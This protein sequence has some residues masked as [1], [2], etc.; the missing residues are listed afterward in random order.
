LVVNRLATFWRNLSPPTLFVASFA[1]LILIGT[2]GFLVLP[3]LHTGPRLSV[4]DALFTATSAVCVTG[5][6]V[7]DTS[8]HFTF[9]GQLWLLLLIQLGGLG[10]LTLTTLIIAVLGRRL[11]LRSEMIAVPSPTAARGD[12]LALTLATGRFMFGVEAVGAVLLWVQWIG[13]FGVGGA[14]WHAVFHSISAFCNAGFS[15]FSDSLIGFARRPFLLL[16]ISALVIIGGLGY[17]ACE[18]LLRW[19]HARVARIRGGRLSTHTFVAVVTSAILL[20]AGTVAFAVIEWNGVLAPMGFIDRVSNAW[21]LSMTPRTAGFNTVSYAR[22][23]NA[24]VLVT[25]FLMFVGGSPGSTAGGVKTTS[26]AIIFAL[27]RSRMAG[28]RYVELHGRTVPDGTIQR[29]VS[30]VLIGSALVLVGLFALTFTQAEQDLALARQS[31]L[32]LFFEAVS[33]F[34]TVGLSMDLTPSLGAASKL[35]LT[36][37]MFLGRVG[38]LA[39]FAAISLSTTR[40]PPGVRAAQEDVIVG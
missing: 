7:V 27:A 8:T 28:R 31:F 11:S 6:A 18:E 25:L 33:A 29:T 19:F 34:A 2:L 14:L 17:L 36:A 23:G 3:G 4:L 12:V 5:L 20:A 39:F 22:L 40:H 30:L 15:T 21:F 24:A 1:G 26:L 35:M 16:T 10:L 32:P 13:D 9:W 37:L 38:P